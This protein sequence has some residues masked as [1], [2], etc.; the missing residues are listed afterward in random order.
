MADGG[1]WLAS[2]TVE[3]IQV[4]SL[5][6]DSAAAACSGIFWLESAKLG[7]APTSS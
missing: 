5:G 6:T 4:V 3:R 1:S 2:S 7:L